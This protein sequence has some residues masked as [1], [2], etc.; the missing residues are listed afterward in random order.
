MPLHLCFHDRGLRRWC[1]V[2]LPWL[3]HTSKYSLKSCP[4]CVYSI[5][6]NV[7]P[8]GDVMPQNRPMPGT[9]WT[10]R[11]SVAPSSTASRAVASASVTVKYVTQYGCT[12]PICGV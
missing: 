11:Q 5:T 6:Q 8:C 10:R 7:T 9:S 1:C 2:W 12:F 3:V 4:H